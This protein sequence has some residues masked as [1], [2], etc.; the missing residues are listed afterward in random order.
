[1]QLERF[2]S[3]LKWSFYEQNRINGKTVDLRKRFLNCAN[4][5]TLSNLENVIGESAKDGGFIH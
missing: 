5:N 3:E 4:E 1:M 2:K